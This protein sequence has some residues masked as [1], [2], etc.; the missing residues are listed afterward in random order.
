MAGSTFGNLFRITTWG[1]S[2]GAA[3]GVVVD[4]CPAGLTL[5]SEDIQKYLNRR[6]PGQ[7]QYTTQRKE[8]DEVEILSGIFEGKTTGTPISM[9]VRNTS[10][11]MQTIPLMKNMDS[12]IIEVADD[13][14]PERL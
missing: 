2:H 6:K 5:C 1:E 3:I 7:T 13:L 4:G 12:V 11:D 9:I 14:L 8:A 10:Q